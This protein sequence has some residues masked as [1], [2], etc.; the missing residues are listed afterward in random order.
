MTRGRPA[1]PRPACGSPV[2]EG[3]DTGVHC[4]VCRSKTVWVVSRSAFVSPK[5]AGQSAATCVGGALEPFAFRC[6]E[7]GGAI[8]YECRSGAIGDFVSVQLHM[9]TPSSVDVAAG[10]G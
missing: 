8:S 2:G 6:S 4:L 10:R 5:I 7:I 1:L 3:R 9:M